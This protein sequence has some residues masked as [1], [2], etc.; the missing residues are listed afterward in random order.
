M[1]LLLCKH[2]HCWLPLEAGGKAPVC[3]VIIL[4]REMKG[5]QSDGVIQLS[6]PHLISKHGFENQ[7]KQS[8]GRTGQGEGKGEKGKEIAS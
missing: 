1:H 8:G 3:G 2:T 7:Q 4:H 6:I 5:L